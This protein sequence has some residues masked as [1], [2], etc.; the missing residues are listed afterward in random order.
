MVIFFSNQLIP[1]T[2]GFGSQVIT[3]DLF[4]MEIPGWLHHA[5]VRTIAIVPALYCVWN[6][7]VEGVFRVLVFTQVLLALLL[8]S[9]MI[10]LF[11]VA[12]SRSIMGTY[13]V[14]VLVEFSALAL[15][16]GMLG[17]K[18]VFVI[19]MIFG[20]SKWVSNMK[21]DICSGI[22]VTLI[23]ATCAALYLRLL[24]ATTPLKSTGV[25]SQLTRCDENVMKPESSAQGART[26]IP[27]QLEKAMDKL[28]PIV[29]PE[30]AIKNN[31]DS[32]APSP[33]LKLPETLLDSESTLDL[34]TIQENERETKPFISRAEA[35]IA[36]SDTAST[37]SSKVVKTELVDA[38]ALKTE[39]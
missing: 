35:L 6:L 15:F 19:E 13:K 26:E 4:R 5:T 11:Q 27:Y 16:L 38:D 25:E 37:E 9:A 28:Q 23:M 34:T 14:S 20:T 12:S 39:S 17:L 10:P 22:Y 32:S 1:L 29:S 30:R 21:W 33:D 31:G 2:W 18:I 7:G 3:Q 36:V 8:P 24:L